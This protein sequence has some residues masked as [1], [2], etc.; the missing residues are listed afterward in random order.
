M[1]CSCKYF[2]YLPPQ[3]HL[4]FFLLCY[5][6]IIEFIQIVVIELYAVLLKRKS[7]QTY[8]TWRASSLSFLSP[9][10]SFPFFFLNICIYFACSYAFLFYRSSSVHS[11]ENFTTLLPHFVVMV[12]LLY[13]LMTCEL[14]FGTWKLA[15]KVSI[16]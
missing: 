4:F 11:G 3:G 16:L 8:E 9:P 5:Y 12:K 6:W 1:I 15:I 10:S 2:V 13:Q 7:Q 14:I